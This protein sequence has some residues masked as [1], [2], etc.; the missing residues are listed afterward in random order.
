[1]LKNS[2]RIV[3][4]RELQHYFYCPHRWGIVHIGCDWSENFFVSKAQVVHDNV[5][6]GKS[7]FLRGK[8]IER[9]VQI[10]N[11]EWGLFGVLDCI[12]LTP[13]SKGCYIDKYSKKFNLEIVEYKPTKSTRTQAFVADKMQI[14]VQKICVDHMFGVQCS[15]CIYYADI[16]KRVEV[17]FAQSDYDDLKHA[18]DEIRLCYAKAIIPL[19]NPS[20]YCGGCSMKDICLPK[21]VK[22][23]A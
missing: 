12:Q 16:R 5:D 22:I 6:S 20:V 13:D 15:A 11:D 19:M 3:N 23:N 14:L 8:Y 1:M 17:I 18:L 4:I 9:S 10:Y 7:S 2:D 21:A